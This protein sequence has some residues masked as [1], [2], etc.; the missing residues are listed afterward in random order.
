MPDYSIALRSNSI[1]LQWDTASHGSV[2]PPQSR[3]KSVHSDELSGHLHHYLTIPVH[4]PLPP[5]FPK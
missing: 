4:D 2:H 5:V 3:L 1:V